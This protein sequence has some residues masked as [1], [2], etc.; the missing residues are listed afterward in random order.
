MRGSCLALP[1]SCGRVCAGGH[2]HMG[3]ISIY[4]RRSRCR[5]RVS[6]SVNV[7]SPLSCS[8]FFPRE[9][10]STLCRHSP[11]HQPP[12]RR[13]QAGSGKATNPSTPGVDMSPRNNISRS[14]RGIII[15]FFIQ[16]FRRDTRTTADKDRE[17]RAPVRFDCI[18][19]NRFF[20]RA[21]HP[22]PLA[23]LTW[24]A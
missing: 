14:E 19:K 13:K 8:V 2:A 24:S 18:H 5:E 3:H 11:D 10:S 22:P 1:L 12:T 6:Y 21:P 17:G 23:H 20:L 9:S 4:I 15:I 16:L 7:S